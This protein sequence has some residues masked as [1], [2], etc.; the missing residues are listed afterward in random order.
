VWE[1]DLVWIQWIGEV[2]VMM[3]TVIAMTLMIHDKHKNLEDCS[4]SS[5]KVF[6]FV[7]CSTSSE[8]MD[9]VQTLK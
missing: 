1:T 9:I 5:M 7:S 2:W 6:S 8:V 3:L 4:E